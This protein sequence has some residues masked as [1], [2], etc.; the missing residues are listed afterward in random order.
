[1]TDRRQMFNVKIASPSGVERHAS[2]NIEIDDKAPIIHF[3]EKIPSTTREKRLSIKGKVE[4]AERFNLNKSPV[5]LQDGQFSIT[6]DLKPG[7]NRLSFVAG[8][9]VGNVA[10]IEKEV[11][12]DPDPPGL[13]KYEISLGKGEDKNQA[14]VIV[15]AQDSTGLIKTAP[16]IVRIGKQS[17]TGHMILSGS[18]GIYIGSFTIPEGGRHIIKLKS[19]TLSDYLGNSKE[20]RF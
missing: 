17:H 7:A 16:F 20:Y 12:F 6:I 1:M 2:I 14:S 11:L 19:V 13:L 9:L 5:S 10:R 18:K 15:K 8:D 4:D 3:D